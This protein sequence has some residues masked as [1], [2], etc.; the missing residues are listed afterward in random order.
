MDLSSG[1]KNEV[2]GQKNI[3]TFERKMTSL[4]TAEIYHT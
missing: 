3:K 4:L 1:F 2:K